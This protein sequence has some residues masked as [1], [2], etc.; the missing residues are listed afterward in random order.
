M[1]DEQLKEY[2]DATNN[3]LGSRAGGR[4]MR[5]MAGPTMDVDD[6]IKPSKAQKPV[7]MPIAPTM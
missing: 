3:R 2:N 6:M 5:A 1:H 4:G 7:M